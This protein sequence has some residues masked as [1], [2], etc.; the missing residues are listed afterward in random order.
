MDRRMIGN[1][2]CAEI[3]V[4]FLDFYQVTLYVLMNSSLKPTYIVK[5]DMN[6]A[7][8]KGIVSLIL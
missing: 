3:R 2:K 4:V 1:H 5:N 8:F 7:V 6:T